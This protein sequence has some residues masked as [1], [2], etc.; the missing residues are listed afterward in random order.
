MKRRLIL[1]SGA[2][3]LSIF[4]IHVVCYF[5]IWMMSHVFTDLSDT[6]ALVCGYVFILT[7]FITLIMMRFS[8]LKWYVDPFA[9]AEFPLLGYVYFIIN[10]MKRG[11]DFISAVSNVNSSLIENGGMLIMILLGLFIFGIISSFS[12]ARVRGKSI[13]YV[14]FVKD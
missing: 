13:S 10:Q 4:L 1:L 2:Y 5:V 8:F 14:L 7:P 9:A 12:I 6:V 3:Y 11:E